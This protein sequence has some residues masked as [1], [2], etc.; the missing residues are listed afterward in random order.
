MKRLIF[1]FL[2]LLCA[3]SGLP[4][5]APYGLARVHH[6]AGDNVSVSWRRRP[7]ADCPALSEVEIL[8]G[9]SKRV[10]VARGNGEGALVAAAS[11]AP[12]STLAYRTRLRC[13]IT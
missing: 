9:S 6:A 5:G 1:V 12:S 8:D 2:A 13:A 10:L 11:L 3:A 4:C 7:G